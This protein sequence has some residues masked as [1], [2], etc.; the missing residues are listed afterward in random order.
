MVSEKTLMRSALAEEYRTGG[1]LR[2]TSDFVVEECLS[3]LGGHE[4]SRNK[5]VEA[6]NGSRYAPPHGNEGDEGRD[7]HRI[8][9][10]RCLGFSSTQ[11]I[12]QR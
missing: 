7:K 11:L 4:G 12:S 10:E 9:F 6:N 5:V 1:V 3:W 8:I 2:D